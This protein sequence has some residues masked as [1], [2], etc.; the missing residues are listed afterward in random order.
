VTIIE[1][2]R[3]HNQVIIESGFDRQLIGHWGILSLLASGQRSP[4]SGITKH[5]VVP[6]AAATRKD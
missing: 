5:A 4:G 2:A 6:S 3:G 1:S